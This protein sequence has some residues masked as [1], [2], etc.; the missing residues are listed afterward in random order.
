MSKLVWVPR[1]I[2]DALD[3]GLES[4]GLELHPIPDDPGA[5][6]LLAEVAL[7][8]A[9]FRTQS[10][11]VTI[12]FAGLWERMTALEVVQVPTAGV[13]WIVETLPERVTLCSARGAH[14]PAVSEWVLAAMLAGEKDLGGFR[15]DQRNARWAPREVRELSG[16]GVLI[17]G[18]GSI[19]RAVERLL[20]PF[21][22]RLWRVAAHERD[23]VQTLDALPG[24]LPE[25]D[26]VVV[27]LPLTPETD[28]L[29]D[30]AFM[31]RMRPG[32]LLVNPARGRVVDT[33]ALLEALV[34]GRIRAVVDVT[35]P[36]P[37]PADHALWRAP[38]ILITPH[39]AGASPMAQERVYALVRAQLARF[40]GGEPLA[41]VVREGY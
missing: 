3:P 37:L 9:P 30:A 41:N 12:Q 2:L 29:V 24:I 5:D 11:D 8:V 15:D 20:E 19:G 35:D 38:G 32:A 22:C 1:D 31:A 21:E 34:S 6:P 18:Y 7:L 36:E 33:A 10:F 14:D 40:A 23:G 27:L 16:A 17:L 4:K 25:A 28:R 26:V 13:D 39:V